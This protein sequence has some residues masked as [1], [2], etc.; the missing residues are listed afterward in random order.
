MEA[1]VTEMTFEVE[2]E[3]S[4]KREQGEGG[5]Q[6]ESG[7]PQ[8]R[9]QGRDSQGRTHRRQQG[10]CPST[11]RKRKRFLSSCPKARLESRADE[12]GR[13][14]MGGILGDN[15]CWGTESEAPSMGG[16][17]RSRRGL[18]EATYNGD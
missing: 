11:I 3:E 2:S 15:V 1:G 7:S 9:T 5:S 13:T 10:F 16:T 18:R 12:T 17:C 8:A 14:A 6:T 4:Q